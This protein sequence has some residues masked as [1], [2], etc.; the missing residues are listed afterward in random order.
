ME[1]MASLQCAV[2][3]DHA[4]LFMQ[5]ACMTFTARNIVSN[6]RTV[7]QMLRLYFQCSVTLVMKLDSGCMQAGRRTLVMSCRR[8]LSVQ[9]LLASRSTLADIEAP[10]C[11]ELGASAD[12]L[13]CKETNT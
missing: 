5:E 3:L 4:V 10:S 11:P 7:T 2:S 13:A 1:D 8:T 6:A 12:S 9:P